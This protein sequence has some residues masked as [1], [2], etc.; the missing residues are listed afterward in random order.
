MYFVICSK[1][2]Y[3]YF[4]RSRDELLGQLK[5]KVNL[6]L[7][8][9]IQ[10]KHL[11][12]HQH[13]EKEE[14]HPIHPWHRKDSVNHY[15]L[16]QQSKKRLRPRKDAKVSQTPS[17][18]DFTFECNL[19]EWHLICS[20]LL[21]CNFVILSELNMA[22]GSFE[23]FSRSLK[24]FF[25]GWLTAGFFIYRDSNW[26]AFQ[27]RFDAL[28]TNYINQASPESSSKAELKRRHQPTLRRLQRRERGSRRL[29]STPMTWTPPSTS[30]PSPS[31]TSLS[32]LHSCLSSYW[33]F[34]TTVGPSGVP[35]P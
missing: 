1:L 32:V 17:L 15:K 21:H 23:E 11:K 30:T 2:Q 35:R 7:N 25:F 34:Q 5:N 14:D 13:R 4:R 26:N 19:W 20:L 10:R 9:K 29:I 16:L 33:R 31:N 18:T 8:L 28:K 24:L 6:K 22:K 3:I 27:F 12:K